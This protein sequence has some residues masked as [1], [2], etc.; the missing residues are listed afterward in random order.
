[1]EKKLTKY[2]RYRLKDVEGYREKK[3]EWAKTP[4]QRKIRTE[5]M[6]VWREKNRE[7][8]NKLCRDSHHKNK[9]KHVEYRREY[10]LKKNYGLTIKDYNEMFSNQLGMCAICK[11]DKPAGNRFHVDH[12]HLTGKV[13]KLLCSRCNGALGWYEKYA[14]EINNYLL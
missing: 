10:N 4:E 6:R 2:D 5:Y 3:R 14:H 11:T 12:D 9:H 7:K 13:R 1:M 8:H